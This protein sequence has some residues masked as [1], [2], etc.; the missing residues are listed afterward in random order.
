MG[1]VD[2]DFL[3][4]VFWQNFS[5]NASCYHQKISLLANMINFQ[6]HFPCF[7]CKSRNTFWCPCS[8]SESFPEKSTQIGFCCV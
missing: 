1:C 8:K 4:L 6:T 3:Y 7:I 2:T 5:L